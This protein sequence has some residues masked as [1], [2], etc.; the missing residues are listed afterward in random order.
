MRG[1][2]STW[3]PNIRKGDYLASL[4]F[5][6]GTVDYELTFK[7]DRKYFIKSQV[8]RNF[9]VSKES[10]HKAVALAKEKYEL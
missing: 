2:S 4:D 1:I 10:H 5:R 3:D 7:S 9:E 6:K 8:F